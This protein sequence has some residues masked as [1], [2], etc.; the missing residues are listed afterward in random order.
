MPVENLALN[1]IFI[2]RP[3][4]SMVTG[5]EIINGLSSVNQA[6]VKGESVPVEKNSKRQVVCCAHQWRAALEIRA[7]RTFA[8]N[9]LARII[10]MVE[11]AQ[12]PRGKSQRFIERFGLRYSPAIL[13]AEIMLALILPLAF[14]L[15]SLKAEAKKLR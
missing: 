5:G 11:E 4:E 12:E 15:S 9:I 1:D 6:P 13:V 7:T 14:P 8:D 2:V 10:Q 3:D